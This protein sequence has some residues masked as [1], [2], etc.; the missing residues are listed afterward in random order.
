[1]TEK[2]HIRPRPIRVAFLIEEHEHWQPMLDAIFADCFDRWG[3]RF[4]L[5]VPRENGSIRGSYVRWLELYDPDIIYSYV[6]LSESEVALIHERFYPSFLVHHGP[7]RKG[8]RDERA[9]RPSLPIQALGSLSVTIG[10]LPG[11]PTS[12]RKP[13]ALLGTR[14]GLRPSQFIQENFGCY[15]RSPTARSMA[16]DMPEFVQTVTF[17][18]EAIHN[19]LETNPLASGDVV[20]DEHVF[21]DRISKERNLIGLSQL[22]AWLCP[23]LEFHDDSWAESICL[24]VGDSFIDRVVFWNGRSHLPV[25]LDSGLVTLKTSKEQLDDPGFFSSLIG[26]IR[27]RIRVPTSNSSS[28]HFRLRSASLTQS[29]LDRVCDNFRNQ[30]KRAFYS[31]EAAITLDS[32]VPS[33]DA[34]KNPKQLTGDGMW[35]Q[36]RDWH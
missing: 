10:G 19:N 26:I 32:C 9:F 33:A 28:A 29:E 16:D 2:A 18:S 5:L 31:A 7:N 17:V 22:S 15:G 27:N 30:D 1:M 23:R 35:F 11:D 13:I 14:R 21:L 12:P 4:N 34:L 20:A 25:W 36:G 8:S 3:G 24:V 6:D